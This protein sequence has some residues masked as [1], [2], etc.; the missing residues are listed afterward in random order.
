LWQYLQHEEESKLLHKIIEKEVVNMA[1]YYH[2]KTVYVGSKEDDIC[3]NVHKGLDIT[4][5]TNYKPEDLIMPLR[6]AG[7]KISIRKG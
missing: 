5:M 1:K 4:R 6:P 2:H 7:I 3:N